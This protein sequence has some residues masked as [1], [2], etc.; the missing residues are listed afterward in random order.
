VFHHQHIQLARERERELSKRARSRWSHI[1]PSRQLDAAATLQSGDLTA[2]VEAVAAGDDRA[3]SALV[4]R[5]RPTVVAVARRHRLSEADQNEVAQET[6]V[7]LLRSIEGLTS[8]ESLPA[9]LATTARNESLRLLRADR[10]H[11][12]LDEHALPEPA[13]DESALVDR[14]A[15]REREAA[16][17][18][19]LD[20]VPVQQRRLL[21]MLVAESEPTYAQVSAALDIPIGSIGPTRARCIARLRGDEELARVVGAIPATKENTR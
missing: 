7:R 18:R 5:F 12:S 21:R 6:W 9:W 8:P 14:V 13:G 10:G 2:L 19:A 16:L 3:W 20:G 17:H 1:N 11:V 4:A 15:G